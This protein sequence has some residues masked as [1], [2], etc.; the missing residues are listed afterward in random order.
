MHERGRRLQSISA[1]TR[2]TESSLAWCLYGCC[3]KIECMFQW[4]ARPPK[5]TEVSGPPAYC[6]QYFYL[7]YYDRAITEHIEVNISGQK[8]VD[9]SHRAS[10]TVDVHFQTIRMVARHCRI[11]PFSTHDGA[12]CRILSYI[13]ILVIEWWRDRTASSHKLEA[14]WC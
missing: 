7:N 2:T 6:T 1:P 13:Y 3:S 9:E 8:H 4:C 10:C 11:L 5:T 14:W 12:T